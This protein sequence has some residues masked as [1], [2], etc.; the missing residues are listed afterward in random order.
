MDNGRMNATYAPLDTTTRTWLDLA[1]ARRLLVDTYPGIVLGL[2]LDGRILW[3]NPAASQRLGYDREELTGRAF[4]DGLVA[5]EEI[6]LQAAHL[7]REFGEPV[8]ADTG[9][10][11]ARLQRG[12]PADE[13]G[14]V[15]KNKEGTLHP[16]R[17]SW[18]LLRDHEGHATGLLAVEPWPRAEGDV[19]PQMVQ[20]D[21][22]TGLATRAVL[23]D[24]AEMALQRAARQ[25]TVVALMLIEL[26]GFDAICEEHGHSV[27]DDILRAT[28]GRLYFELRKTD[29]A[30]RLERGQFVAMLV[31]L[32][33][34]KDAERVAQKTAAALSA[35]VNV[36]V[37][38]IPLSARIGVSWYPAHGDQLLPLIEAADK[39]LASV[40]ASDSG[41]ACAPVSA[42]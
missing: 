20:H 21:S 13:Q 36:G 2:D 22:L 29:T 18:A 5:R 34:P 14:W 41:A 39:A 42:T 7:A 35:P 12:A 9:V 23:P 16:A 4:V 31:D 3:I 28:A 30:V 37:A 25:K 27:G 11:T 6:E 10:L 8:A 1:E 24:R 19:Q 33:D 17:L 15:L 26:T 32:N 38:R 40:P